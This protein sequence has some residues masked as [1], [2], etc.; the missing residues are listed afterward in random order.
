MGYYVSVDVGGTF[1]DC[2]VLNEKGK[3]SMGKSPTIPDNPVQG[4][5]NTLKV[6]AEK[7]NQLKL[8]DFLASC[9]TIIVGSTVATNAV[10]QD[11][12][13]RCCMITTRGFR[14]ILEMRPT[15]KKDIYNFKLSKPR[16]LIPRHLRFEV[17]ERTLVSGEVLT[18][19]NEENAR[20][21]CRKAK[22]QKCEVVVVCFLHS[23]VNNSHE[24]KMAAIIREEYPEA[25]I[26]LS[27]SVL[28]RP[29]EYDRFSTAALAGYISHIC[30][31][32][33]K[34]LESSLLKNRFSGILLITTSNAGVTTVEQAMEQPIQ[35]LSSGPAAGV[36][37]GTF[38]GNLAGYSDIITLDIGGTSSD[39]SVIPDGRILTTNESMVGDQKNASHIVDVRSIG[40]GGGSIASLD[41]RGILCVGPQS[42]GADP[43]PACYGKGGDQPAVTDADVVLGYIPADYFLGGSL[44]LDRQLAENAI[45][46]E[47]AGP[48]NISVHEA[49]YSICAVVNAAMSNE[50]LLT[51]ASLGFDPRDYILCIAGGAGAVHGFDAAARLGIRKIYIPKLAA[52]F[53]AFGMMSSADFKYEFSRP[54]PCLQVNM[55]LNEVNRLYGEMETQGLELLGRIKGLGKNAIKIL[56]GADIRY[57]AQAYDIEAYIPETKPGK[58]INNSD[59]DAMFENFHL[60]HE[61]IYGHADRNMMATTT[62]LR[63]IIR[64]ERPRLQIEE[65]EAGNEDPSPAFKRIRPVYFHDIK[66]IKEVQCYDGDKL[67]SGN[68]IKGPAIIEEKTTTVVIPEQ[69]RVSVDRWGNYFGTLP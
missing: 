5:I 19:L 47:I 10:I 24:R 13:A 44:T 4:I 29:P 55:D 69:A 52:A 63:L 18:V 39:V 50:I 51:C 57:F 17:E 20:E 22:Q 26:V 9:D 58:T 60:R 66:D 30:S 16:I 42:A 38:M 2:I 28:P 43:G 35:L 31:E 53:C 45:K 49:A 64:G 25:E 27:S 48:L 23:Y 8:E 36:L 1:T 34:N 37:A 59:L 21:A 40:A 15:V 68:I 11:K 56:R 67:K 62:G 7:E 6:V 14:D 54:L 46:K 61:E 12:G 33:L 3:Y 41:R 65:S 32:F